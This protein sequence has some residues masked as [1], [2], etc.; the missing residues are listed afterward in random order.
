MAEVNPNPIIETVVVLSRMCV[1]TDGTDVSVF[2]FFL[3][4]Y[5]SRKVSRRLNGLR[6]WDW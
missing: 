6:L 5:A 4:F 2:F 3:Q 1:G